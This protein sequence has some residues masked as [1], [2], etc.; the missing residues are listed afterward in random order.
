MQ[1]I[2]LNG[3]LALTGYNANLSAL[4]QPAAVETGLRTLFSILPAAASAIGIL[5]LFAY[6][7]HGER[8]AAI[9]RAPAAGTASGS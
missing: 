1:V 5:A 4:A 7:L 9:R 2:A 6:P 8:L 3:M